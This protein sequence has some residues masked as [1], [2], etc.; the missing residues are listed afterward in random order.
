MLL[1]KKI[2]QVQSQQHTPQTALANKLGAQTSSK[3]MS[4]RERGFAQKHAIFLVRNITKIRHIRQMS[5]KME[6]AK[7]RETGKASTCTCM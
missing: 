5:Q 4:N 2:L 1:Q 3:P 7:E 6:P